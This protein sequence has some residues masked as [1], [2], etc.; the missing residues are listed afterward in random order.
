MQNDLKSK[1]HNW[2]LD[3]PVKVMN[4]RSIFS[5]LSRDIKKCIGQTTEIRDDEH[6][7]SI[8]L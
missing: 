5:V 3:P 8:S 1:C 6:E 7:I 2:I 4:I